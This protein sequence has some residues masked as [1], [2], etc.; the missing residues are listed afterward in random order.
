MSAVEARARAKIAARKGLCDPK[1]PGWAVMATDRG[2]EI[3]RCDD[4]FYG[5][6]PDEKLTDDEAASLPEAGE[7]LRLETQ[8]GEVTRG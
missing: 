1:C 6:A 5:L 4:C 3:E 7:A 2:P 8:T